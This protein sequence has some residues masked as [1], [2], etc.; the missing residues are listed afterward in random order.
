M[1]KWEH[2]L[3]RGK[4]FSISGETFTIQEFPSAGQSL[5]SQ[6]KRRDSF[7]RISFNSLKTVFQKWTNKAEERRK[8]IWR[9]NQKLIFC[10]TKVP[11]A[12]SKLLIMLTKCFHHIHKTS[13]DLVIRGLN[14]Q[15]QNNVANYR[16]QC[17]N[18]VRLLF[19]ACRTLISMI[20]NLIFK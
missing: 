13:L 6:G 15:I 4:Y 14:Y 10:Y 17:P 11:V 5:S 16:I 20:V 12:R 3:D 7:E 1:E 9:N 2:P 18:P 8:I 19:F